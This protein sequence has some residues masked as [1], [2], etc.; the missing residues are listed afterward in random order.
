M[1]PTNI[2]LPNNF[3]AIESKTP[4]VNIDKILNE[5]KELLLFELPKNVTKNILK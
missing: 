2:K 1:E 3:Q 5:D 4:L